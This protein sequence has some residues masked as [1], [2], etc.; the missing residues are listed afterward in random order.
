MLC[1]S[2]W[3]G[4]RSLPTFVRN[5]SLLDSHNLSL[6]KIAPQTGHTLRPAT[7]TTVAAEWPEIGTFTFPSH[8]LATLCPAAS[9]V[10]LLIWEGQP[11][12]L[13]GA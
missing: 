4:F 1:E 3:T 2:L 5:Y 7:G 8:S 13:T 10:L 11:A 12:K 9:E 6:S